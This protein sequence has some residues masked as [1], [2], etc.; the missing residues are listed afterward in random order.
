MT[1]DDYNAFGVDIDT[2]ITILEDLESN[3]VLKQTIE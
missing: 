2:V 3:Y 1:F